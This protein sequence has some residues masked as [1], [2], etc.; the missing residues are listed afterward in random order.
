MSETIIKVKNLTTKF[1]KQVI[2]QNL[3]LDI[4]SQE[5][6][7][8][9]G[10]SG[11]GK[12]VLF[13]FLNKLNPIQSGIIEYKHNID[14]SCGILFQTGG[15]ISFL[16]VIE[17]T[18]LPLIETLRMPYEEA[19]KVAKFYLSKVKILEKDFE[20]FPSNISGG[21]TKK[22]GVARALV[23][24]PQILFLDEPT[25]GLDPISAQEFDNMILDLRKELKLTCVIVTHD[26]HSIFNISDRVAILINKKIISGTLDEIVNNDNPWIQKY[27]NGSRA[28]QVRGIYGK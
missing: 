7:S 17:N 4:Y 10:S 12:S 26:L 25:S 15:L 5:I 1:G 19:F 20:K 3:S 9:V 24:K 13:N 28:K 8:L 21:M 16:T 2:H 11:S 6:L 23:T 18:M 14:K 22:V 27:F